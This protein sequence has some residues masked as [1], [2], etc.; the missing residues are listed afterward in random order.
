MSM[1]EELQRELNYFRVLRH[2]YSVGL[3]EYGS[4]LVQGGVR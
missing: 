2:A 1:Y 4:K 3:E